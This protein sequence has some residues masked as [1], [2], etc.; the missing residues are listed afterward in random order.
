MTAVEEQVNQENPAPHPDSFQRRDIF[1]GASTKI[2][3]RHD[4]ND[5]TMR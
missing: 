5:H 1:N 3:N 2:V 4:N